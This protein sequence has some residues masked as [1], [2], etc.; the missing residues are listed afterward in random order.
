MLVEV[1]R[2]R[3]RGFKIEKEALERARPVRGYIFMWDYFD[4]YKRK[5][6]PVVALQGH[7]SPGSTHLIPRLEGARLTRWR[8]K[9]LVLVGME[10]IDISRRDLCEY[11]QAWWVRIVMDPLTSLPATDPLES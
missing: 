1:V 9:G 3:S 4:Q 11:S 7:P 10:Q 5:H 2:L 6:V 8:A